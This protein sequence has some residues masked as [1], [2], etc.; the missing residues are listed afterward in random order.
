[1]K[2]L[3]WII[4]IPVIAVLSF[5]LLLYLFPNRPFEPPSIKNKACV[6]VI[7]NN[8]ISVEGIVVNMDLDNSGV[9][10]D[11]GDTLQLL[12]E[13]YYGCSEGDVECVLRLCGCPIP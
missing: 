11:S 12:A 4:I 1:M 5:F 2:K 9:A 3:Y 10:G 13:R 8:C 7:R 6:D